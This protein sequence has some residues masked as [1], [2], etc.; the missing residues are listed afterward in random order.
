MYQISNL[1]AWTGFHSPE[2]W[3]KESLCRS[4]S[5]PPWPLDLQYPSKTH[6]YSFFSH[7]YGRH[8]RWFRSAIWPRRTTQW[9]WCPRRGPGAPRPHQRLRLPWRRFLGDPSS[10]QSLQCNKQMSSSATSRAEYLLPK[11]LVGHL[12]SLVFESPTAAPAPP[13]W[14]VLST[15]TDSCGVYLCLL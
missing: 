11:D 15:S 14:S 8:R 6:A 9:R 3:R 12:V 13:I 10:P 1:F 5:S 2:V 7:H 4:R